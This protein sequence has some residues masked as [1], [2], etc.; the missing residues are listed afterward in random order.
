MN[1]SE[2]KLFCWKVSKTIYQ[3][4]MDEEPDV[5][6]DKLFRWI[7]SQPDPKLGF[8]CLQQAYEARGGSITIHRL[9]TAA[10]DAYTFV[11]TSLS[12]TASR[13]SSSTGSSSSPTKKKTRGPGKRQRVQDIG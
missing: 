8:A 11:N 12:R 9:L 13:A 4:N 5:V 10:A 1:Q 2:I 6:G 7:E 3:S